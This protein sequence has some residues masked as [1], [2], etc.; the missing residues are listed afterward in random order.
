MNA[1][2][3][4]CMCVSVSVSGF[5]DDDADHQNLA[6]WYLVFENILRKYWNPVGYGCNAYSLPKLHCG[7]VCV[8]IIAIK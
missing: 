2:A 1:G 6:I 4:V 5:G 7:Y 8:F 3:S